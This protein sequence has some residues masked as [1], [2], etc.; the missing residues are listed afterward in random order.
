MWYVS[1]FA[2][3]ALNFMEVFMKKILSGVLAACMAVGVCA[4]ATGCNDT[5]ENGSK[6]EKC[7]ITFD[8]DGKEEAIAFKLYMNIAPDTIEHFKYLAGK[9]YYDGTVV[10]DV[11]HGIEFGAYADAAFNTSLEDK[12]GSIINST[13]AA[14]KKNVYTS[15]FTIV[16]EM[17]DNGVVYKGENLSLADGALVLKRSLKGIKDADIE[18]YDTGKGVMSVTF[19]T[20]TY[21]SSAKSFAIIGKADKS[22]ATSDV[23]SSYSRIKTIYDDNRDAS[24][25]TYYFSYEPELDSEN[26]TAD[27]QEEYDNLVKALEEYG[28]KYQVGTD[29]DTFVIGADGAYSLKVTS[30]DDLGKAYLNAIKNNGAYVSLRPETTITIKSVTFSK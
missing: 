16:G 25:K 14:T 3:C 11:Q 6:I 24:V 18:A 30:D 13:Y 17:S 20:S 4:F 29:G 9:G 8:V 2:A 5:I 27:E 7:T 15:K 21:F 19:G 1:G 23:K 10:S 12:Y 28:R 22:D 26:P